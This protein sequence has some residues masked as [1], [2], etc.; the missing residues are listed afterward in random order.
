MVPVQVLPWA[1]Q[2]D[3]LHGWGEDAYGAGLECLRRAKGLGGPNHIRRLTDIEAR[4]P[5][6]AY[7]YRI[8][9]Q[10]FYGMRDVLG[11]VRLLGRTA[12]LP[13]QY[14]RLRAF[15]WRSA[16]TARRHGP[17]GLPGAA[18]RRVRRRGTL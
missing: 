12:I 13:F 4:A 2:L 5:F 1:G 7:H 6:D 11:P 17:L 15:V 10:T 14:R 8:I 16:R 18:L 3:F 9:Y